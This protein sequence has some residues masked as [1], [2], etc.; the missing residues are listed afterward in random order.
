MAFSVS[1]NFGTTNLKIDNRHVF[2]FEISILLP[3]ST[4]EG[5]L[6]EKTC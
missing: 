2:P 1:T 5:G 3:I 6:R 4:E